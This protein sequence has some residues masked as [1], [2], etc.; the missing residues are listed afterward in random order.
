MM[1]TTNMQRPINRT[2]A[3]I[4][5]GIH[6]QTGGQ[7]VP[8]SPKPKLLD[9]VRDA[10]RARHYSPRTEDTYVHWIKRFIFFHNKRHPI[11]MAE[12]D[13]ARFLSSLATQS[14]VSASTQNQA[15]NAILFLYRV[16][17]QKSIGYVD[18]VIRAKRPQR[19]PV[20][21]TKDEVKSVLDALRD[22][23]WLMA[24]LLYGAGLRLMECCHLRVKDID[25]AQNQILVRS[26]KGDKDRHTTL[27]AVVKAPLLRH[28]DLV[29]RQHENDIAKGVG[30]VA[31]PDALERKYPNAG[32]EWGWQWVFPATS[33]FT[34]AITGEKRRHHLHE[35]VLQR[36]FKEARLKARVSKPA[37]C[38]TLRH[39]FAT[40]LLEDGYDIRTVQELLGHKDVSTTMIYTHVLNR[41][42]RGV[43]SPAD[44]LG[45]VASCHPSTPK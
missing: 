9:Q 24:L 4:E 43:H 12:T 34:D 17:L 40:H 7:A 39:S 5:G 1:E 44:R 16:V 25:F 20:V 22:T 31:L 45:F 38:H 41:G 30:R 36:A 3:V 19:L 28:L 26:G 35:S 27:P 8:L 29:R 23:P 6:K 32:K 15:L 14:R 10:I 11:E 13:I 18:G 33:H 42:G 21:L 2:L 37:S